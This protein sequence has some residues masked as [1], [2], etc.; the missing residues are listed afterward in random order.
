MKSNNVAVFKVDVKGEIFER[1]LS[2]WDRKS[3]RVAAYLGT[4]PSG[5]YL[6]G[7]KNNKIK[8]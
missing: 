2:Y 4:S 1:V 8:A 6:F 3:G 5:T 7:E